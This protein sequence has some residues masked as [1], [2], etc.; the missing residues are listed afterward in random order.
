MAKYGLG[1]SEA[2]DKVWT[3]SPE[4]VSSFLGTDERMKQNAINNVSNN[5]LSLSD[6]KS[7]LSLQH[8]RG[9][10]L[11][12]EK[13]ING[14]LSEIDTNLS[15]VVLNPYS[16]I[17]IETAHEAVWKDISKHYKN[18][19]D[20]K[21]PT[22]ICYEEYLFAGKH[23]CRACRAFTK[24]YD[25]T[26]SHS[27]FGHLVECR[28]VLKYLLHELMLIKNIMIYYLGDDYRDEDEEQVT[29]YLTDWIKTANHYTKQ[30][31]KEISTRTVFLPETELDQVNKK[32]ASQ[33]QAFFSI[34]INSYTTEIQTLLHLIKRDSVDTA[35]TFYNNYLIPAL[36][37]KSKVIEPMMLEVNTTD[38][39]RNIPTLLRELY[40]ANSAIT[41]NFGAISADIIERNKQVYKRFDAFLQAINLKRRY[42]NYMIQLESKAAKRPSILVSEV[43]EKIDD[44]RRLFLDTPVDKSSR[45]NLR[46]SHNDLDDIDGDAHPQYLRLDGGTILGDI[47]VSSG[48]KIAGIDLAEHTHSGVDGSK[49]ISADDI[50]YSTARENYYSATDNLP[51]GELVLTSLTSTT[52]I[53]GVPQYE[54][55]FE[56]EIDD[57]KLNSYEFEILYKELET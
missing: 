45:D 37:V 35:T 16:N 43:D 12:T 19:L 28:Q 25:L 36:N 49:A 14:L 57:D 23:R 6:R 30:I 33:F 11:N 13:N 44:Y 39:S 32:Q 8:A 27:S 3:E 48:V 51:Y 7:S 20:L 17:E 42:V 31:A 21:F 41:G 50:N 56:I 47:M 26:I 22:F 24:E 18:D 54:A 9:Y 10:V 29:K 46:S 53:G 55:V 1:K 15:Q 5:F 34:K 40:V 2:T 38:L 52:L 4:D